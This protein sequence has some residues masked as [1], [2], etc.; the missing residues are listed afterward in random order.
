[1]ADDGVINLDISDRSQ[2]G[3]EIQSHNEKNK[4]AIK[5]F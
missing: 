2:I 3:Q 5:R 1:M 4:S